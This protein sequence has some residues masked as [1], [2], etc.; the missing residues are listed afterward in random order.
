[1]FRSV[2]AKLALAMA[3]V[4]AVALG[5]VYAIVVPRLERNLVAAKVEALRAAG[6]PIA[7]TFNLSRLSPQDVRVNVED[8]VDEIAFSANARVIVYDSTELGTVRV[9]ADS[10]RRSTDVQS[11]P[12]ALRAAAI[13][14]P[15]TGTVTREDERFAEAAFPLYTQNGTVILFSSSLD[16]TLANV[17]LVKRRVLVAA[18]PALLVAVLLGYG[19]ASAFAR[20]IRALERAADRIAGGRFDEP[21]PVRGRDELAELARTF[22]RMRRR[23]AQL[24]R[25]RREFIANASHELRTPIFSLGGFLE[26]LS[27]EDLDEDT[28]REFL[29]TMQEQVERLQKLATDLLDLSRLDAGQLLVEL[30]PVGLRGV[31]EAVADEFAAIAQVTGHEL[32]V[33]GDG[34]ALGDEQRVLQIG[35]ILVE[36]A[37]RHTPPGTAIRIDVA[38]TGGAASLT[39]EDE[40]PG[41]PVEHH[42][43]VFDRFYRVDGN[44]ASGSGLGLAIAREL[45]ELMDGSLELDGAAGSTRFRLRLPAAAPARTP[46]AA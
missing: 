38:D 14:T 8:Y 33:S 32:T 20:R 15:S 4:V 18:V 42:E 36:N 21:V 16:D 10:R 25:A 23:L 39:V 46:I 2:G 3:L 22:E 13:V 6:E 17:R 31:A 19:L 1:M 35:R 37:I 40:G 11:D 5:V 30:E 7:R 44:R 43:Q 12:I 41:I 28:R 26:L 45:A 27:S 29:G 34:D 24:E 9:I